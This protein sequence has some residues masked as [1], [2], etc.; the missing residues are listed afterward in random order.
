MEASASLLPSS[1]SSVCDVASTAMLIALPVSLA[2]AAAVSWNSAAV[3]V[4]GGPA[5]QAPT[6]VLAVVGGS[7][8]QPAGATTTRSTS[9]AS[10]AKPIPGKAAASGPLLDNAASNVMVVPGV[11]SAGAA[12]A[13]TARSALDTAKYAIAG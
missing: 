9:S 5:A 3:A 2:G 1:G 12:L 6:V 13:V 11:T 10:K 4:A 8:V 7:Q